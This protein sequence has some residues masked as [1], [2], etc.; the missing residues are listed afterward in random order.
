MIEFM[1]A[2]ALI[3]IGGMIIGAGLVFWVLE[4]GPFS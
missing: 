1:I 3:G 2:G 4:E